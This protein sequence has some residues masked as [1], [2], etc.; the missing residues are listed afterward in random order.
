[1]LE[2]TR[3][4]KETRKGSTQIF[5]STNLALKRLGF[6][7]LCLLSLA[8]AAGACS[9]DDAEETPPPAG[10]LSGV[11]VEISHSSAT[12]TPIETDTYSERSTTFMLRVSGPL[13][14]KV[15]LEIAPVEGLAFKV[16]G[17]FS[18]GA[19]TFVVTV[20]YDGIRAILEGSVTLKLHLTNVPESHRTQTTRIAI[21]DGRSRLRPIPVSRDNIRGFN[22][23]ANT[24]QGLSRHYRLTEDVVLPLPPPSSDASNWTPIGS[25][26]SPF[27]G[28]FDGNGFTLSGLAANSNG[29]GI[30]GMF[31]DTTRE[32]VIENLGL[33]DLSGNASKWGLAVGGLVGS[34]RGLVRNCY[35]SG[36]VEGYED[37]GGL[38]GRNEGG[39]VQDSYAT[40]SVTGNRENW[41]GRTLGGLVGVNSGGTVQDSYATSSVTGRAT[42]GGLVGRNEGGTVQ[43]SYA[44]GRVEGGDGVG[45]LVGG[46]SSGTVQNCYATGNVSGKATGN[47]AYSDSLGVSVGG[48]V[49]SSYRG[50]VQNCYA[51]GR[52]SAT[53]SSLDGSPGCLHC[54]G[55]SQF[56]D[57]DYSCRNVNRVGGLVGRGGFVENSMALNPS[58]TTSLG[59]QIGRVVGL[60]TLSNNA[61]FSGMTGHAWANIG[62]DKLDGAS[63]TAAQLQTESGFPKELRS[64]PWT[65]E[66]GRL[67]GLFG[68]TVAM[69]NHIPAK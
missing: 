37:V 24:A 64:G 6:G 61:A 56:A 51:T 59:T 34:N 44:T 65:Y 30:S 12:L 39:T 28:S 48:V 5:S 49:G 41:G 54:R 23:Y 9:S 35:V 26:L 25:F 18:E 60:G 42:L 29:Y 67:P 21:I 62:P 17:H 22:L 33:I 43:D 47:N 57:C 14:E 66:P 27:S 3:T 4:P 32:V 2:Q 7:A 36:N 13:A 68:K 58:V 10:L 46:N 15:E 8:M 38:V 11:E 19:K 52:V 55:I 20:L 31:G 40:G 1:M 45:G 50:T 16:S 63:K 69:P 53:G